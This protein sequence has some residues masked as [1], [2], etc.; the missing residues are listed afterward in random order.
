M[1]PFDR[2]TR[3]V[4]ITGMGIISPIGSAARP[5]WSSLQARAS[6]IV[7]TIQMFATAR[8]SAGEWRK[9][10]DFTDETAKKSI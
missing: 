3:R 7:R 9:I 5:F 10:K 8:S 4:V 6:G 1:S 2:P